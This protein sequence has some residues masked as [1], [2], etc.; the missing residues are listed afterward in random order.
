MFKYLLVAALVPALS[1]AQSLFPR[2][3]PN[4][5]SMPAYMEINGCTTSPC[6]IPIGDPIA[7]YAKGIVSPIDTQTLTPSLAI[8]LL[9]LEIPFPIPESLQDACTAGTDPGTCPVSAGQVFDYI[10]YYEDEPFPISGVTV[11]VEVGLKGDDGSY[12]TCVAFDVYI[13]S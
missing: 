10:L 9:G 4:G 3:C 13:Q 5:A 12:I 2:Q 1:L 6:T 11:E 7:A 8:R